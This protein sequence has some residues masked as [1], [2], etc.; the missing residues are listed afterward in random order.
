[1]QVKRL[2]LFLFVFIALN[3]FYQPIQ[4]NNLRY[5]HTIVRQINLD[6]DSLTKKILEYNNRILFV[7][8]I[9]L[10][11]QIMIIDQTVEVNNTS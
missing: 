3:S 5:K 1:M 7:E 9:A 4:I 8:Y 10:N 2:I 6:E 11:I